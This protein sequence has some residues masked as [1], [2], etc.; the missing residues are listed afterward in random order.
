MPV[1]GWIGELW[2][3]VSGT[4]PVPPTWV[5]AASGGIA[6]L[7]VAT[8]STWRLARKSITAGAVLA[9]SW[10]A[11]AAVQA[12]FGYT[13]AWFLLLGGVRAVMEL[14]GDRR[15]NRYR[16]QVS[17]TDAD[18]LGRLTGV[19]GGAWVAIFALLCV[20]ALVLGAH[21]L[22]PN[23]LHFQHYVLHLPH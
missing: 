13:A 9:V 7:I 12:V 20:A 16:G 2:D 10:F 15:R 19:P 1:L 5:I 22:I 18:Q 17:M 14:Q 8:V 6:V 3:R 4:Q 11:T 21:L 23:V